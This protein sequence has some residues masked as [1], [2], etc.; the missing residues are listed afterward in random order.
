MNKAEDKKLTIRPSSLNMFFD[1]SYK[2]FRDNIHN[3]I[4]HVGYSAHCGTAIHKASEEYYT[5]CINKQNWS[6]YSSDYEGLA[7]DTFRERIKEEEPS[8]I[9]EININDTENLIK[10]NVKN[11]LVNA[12]ALNNDKLPIAVEKTYNVEVKSPYVKEVAGTLD[13]VGDDYIVDIKTM[14]RLKNPK[15]YLLQQGVYAFLRSKKG[16]NV[17]DLLIHRIVTKENAKK[18]DCVSILGETY[19]PIK[20]VID[21]SQFYLT[22]I[23]KTC[24]EFFKTGN[25]ILFK[26]NPNSLLCSDKYCAYYNEC[27]YRKCI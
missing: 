9:K 13:I 10:S 7:I 20:D 14:G 1:C 23:I 2:W 12:Q 8:D 4:R 21:R 19:T 5:N 18:V 27:P 11:Y 16:E 26:G 22:T 6:K 17:N 24:N 15:D 25:E 3:P